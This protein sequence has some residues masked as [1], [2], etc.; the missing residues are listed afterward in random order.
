MTERTERPIS[1]TPKASEAAPWVSWGV[2]GVV[3][4][5]TELATR[6]E[7][8]K[9]LLRNFDRLGSPQFM[10]DLFHTNYRETGLDAIVEIVFLLRHSSVRRHVYGTN[11][12]EM[13]HGDNETPHG[14]LYDCG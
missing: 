9:A 3:E 5:Q 11:S 10:A 12:N 7:R 1:T 14:G 4:L 13:L 2:V 8:S 6:L